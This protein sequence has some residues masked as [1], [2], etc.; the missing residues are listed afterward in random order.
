MAHRGCHS[1]THGDDVV[2]NKLHRVVNGHS[3]GDRTSGGIDVEVDV[4]F[5]VLGGEQQIIEEPAPLPAP[6]SVPEPPAAPLT[7]DAP[8][9][10]KAVDQAVTDA[11]VWTE[12]AY[13]AGQPAPVVVS[14]ANWA[15]VV[16]WPQ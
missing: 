14:E 9:V 4:L 12:P 3:R 13:E 10:Q 5:R 11:Q 7:I 6:E 8:S 15:G 1:N 16:S 2:R